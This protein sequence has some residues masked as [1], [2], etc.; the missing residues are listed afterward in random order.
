M[1]KDQR[2]KQTSSELQ[3]EIQQLRIEAD[4]RFME[5]LYE[6]RLRFESIERIVADESHSG[7]VF[8]W[9][10]VRFLVRVQGNLW[11]TADIRVAAPGEIVEGGE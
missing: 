4:A 1:K 5:Q 11:I 7:M 3:A 6:D 9:E 8:P 10:V 2:D